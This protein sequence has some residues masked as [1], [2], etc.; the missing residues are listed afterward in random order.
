MEIKT[1]PRKWGNSLA[2]I[3]PK[4]FVEAH[5]IKENHEITIEIKKNLLARD[6]FGMFPRKSKQRAQKIKDEMRKGW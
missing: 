6:F 4:I 1:R 2:I 5:K 3:L